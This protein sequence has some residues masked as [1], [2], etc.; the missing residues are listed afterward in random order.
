MRRPYASL[1]DDVM[2][3]GV[4]NDCFHRSRTNSANRSGLRLIKWLSPNFR[5][6]AAN[7][8][9]AA[10]TFCSVRLARNFS[11]GRRGRL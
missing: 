5:L 8:S 7:C 11:S 4:A 9:T 10:F 3:G 1:P 2:D 6:R